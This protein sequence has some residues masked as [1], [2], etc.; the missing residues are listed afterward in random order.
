MARGAVFVFGVV[1]AIATLVVTIAIH[2][3]AGLALGFIGLLLFFFMVWIGFGMMRFDM[4]RTTHYP[5]RLNRSNRMVYV[6]RPGDTVL[7]VPWDDLFLCVKKNNLTMFG[8]S[9]D[10]RAHVL[11]EDGETVK[12]TFTLAYADLAGREGLL[13]LWEFIRQYMEEPGGVQQCCEK[14]TMCMPVDG[15]REGLA[16]GIV[17]VFALAANHMF[18]QL[19]G[20]PIAAL[21]VVGRWLAMYT[22]KTPV[23]PTDVETACPIEVDDPYQKDWR[24]N[25]SYGFWELGWPTICFVVGLGVIV[26]VGYT[27]YVNL[28][29]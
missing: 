11:A 23:W 21:N 2:E 13:Q 9:W 6:T 16:F 20:S 1:A 4:F 18:V 22:R 26:A 27:V 17:R 8:T 14:L 12:E 15:R 10:V 25:G 24:D 5:I 3:L 29:A 7:T 19:I 28:G